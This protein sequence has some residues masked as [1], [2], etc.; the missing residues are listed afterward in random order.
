MKTKLLIALFAGC[1]ALL[2]AGTPVQAV[3]LVTNG[4]FETGNLTGFTDTSDPTTAFVSATAA[5]TGKYGYFNAMAGVD[6]ILAQ[7]VATRRNFTYVYS[8]YLVSDGTM[9]NDV[10]VKLGDTVLLALTNAAGFGYTQFTGDVVA[11]RDN[12]ALTFAFRNDNGSFGLDDVSLTSTSVP[13]LPEPA[14]WALL[15]TGFGLTGIA[16]RRRLHVVSC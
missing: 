12:A 2:V 8:F 14:A 3:E 4:G 11:D 16:T 15:A 5:H 1:A 9:P 10:T 13:P 6:G 7:T